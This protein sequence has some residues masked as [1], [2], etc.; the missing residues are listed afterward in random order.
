MQ[1]EHPEGCEV[2][3]ISLIAR[4]YPFELRRECAY[5]D[6]D[7]VRIW[8]FCAD[9]LRYGVQ[10]VIQDCM[11]R[12]KGQ[13]LGDGSYTSTALAILTGDTSIMEKLITNALDTSFITPTL[14]TCSPCSFMQ[15][16]AEYVL[17]LPELMLA[18]IK[19][20]GSLD[21]ARENYKR[22]AAVL[23]AYQ[24]EYEREDHLLHDLDKWCV[25]DWPQE[26]RDGYD[27]A[28]TEGRVAKGTHNVINAYYICAIK[29]LNRIASLLGLPEYRHTDELEAAYRAAFF[30]EER[31][32]FRDAPKSSH[33]ALPS[34]AM[35]LAVGL[36]PDSETKAN[37]I[38]MIRTKPVSASAFFMTFASLAG[39]KR[40]GRDELV[41][42]LIKNDGRWL[43]M[44][45]EGATATFEA[46]GRDSKW[47]TSLFHLCYTFAVIF[48]CDWGIDELFV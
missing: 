25:V 29:A 32:L 42:E 7:I 13:Y 35:A 47:N 41:T 27:F 8:N 26:A 14:M 37:I 2:D 15:E 44:L 45:R 36:C 10:E 31:H 19:L 43:N 18:Q 17:M 5:D 6:P 39:L 20:S 9:S 3:D 48:L 11:E 28:L 33:S 1:L 12:E 22:A 34:N 46:W 16:I 30:D 38:E 40:E 24:S 23:D 21:F 4:H